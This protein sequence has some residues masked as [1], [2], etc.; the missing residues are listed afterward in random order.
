VRADEPAFQH[1]PCVQPEVPPIRDLQGVRRGTGGAGRAIPRHDRKAGARAQPS[2]AGGGVAIGQ[3][4]DGL[5]TLQID[6]ERAPA[7]PAAPGP[8]VDPD[9]VRPPGPRERGG[10]ISRST[11]DPLAGLASRVSRRAPAR[12]PVAKPTCC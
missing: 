6:D 1:L 12:A 2:R 3:E 11:V 8:V 7:A 9:D 4:V 5:M 10:G